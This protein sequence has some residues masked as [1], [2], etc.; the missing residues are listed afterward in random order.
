MLHEVIGWSASGA[1]LVILESESLLK[2][3]IASRSTV[4]DFGEKKRV[5]SEAPL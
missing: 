1:N 5:P 2:R 4:P 3:L